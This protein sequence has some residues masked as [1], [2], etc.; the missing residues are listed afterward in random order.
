MSEPTDGRSL[1]PSTRLRLHF[2]SCFGL[3]LSVPLKLVQAFQAFELLSARY[4]ENP[5]LLVDVKEGLDPG[6]IEQPRVG[7]GVLVEL[8]LCV[9]FINDL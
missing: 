7:H 3:H 1:N 9:Y 6:S 5:A 4:N 2:L 8:M